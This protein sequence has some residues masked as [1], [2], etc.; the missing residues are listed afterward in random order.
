MKPGQP[1]WPTSSWGTWMPFLLPETWSAPK[2]QTCTPAERG[3]N[4][5]HGFP[6]V[7]RISLASHSAQRGKI[8]GS[9]V[10]SRTA[11]LDVKDAPR[12]RRKREK[13]TELTTDLAV[14]MVGTSAPRSHETCGQCR[15]PMW[16]SHQ[17]T[18]STG[19]RSETD[20][21]RG[22]MYLQINLE[23]RQG[24]SRLGEANCLWLPKTPQ[25][26]P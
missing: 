19:N 16:K 17:P 21:L 22:F 1:A 4:L 6:A 7:P 15:R 8:G 25:T 14:A 10:A 12:I 9:P 23:P 20:F 13:K 2:G 3:G 11:K 24:A 18:E 26:R 5:G